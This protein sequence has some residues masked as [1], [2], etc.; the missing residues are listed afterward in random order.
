MFVE[1]D[2]E[3]DGILIVRELFDAERVGRLLAVAEELLHKFRTLNP[4]DGKPASKEAKSLFQIHH[5]G[6]FAPGSPELR[7]LLEAVADPQVLDLVRDTCNT[8]DPMFSHTS[9]F[10]NPEEFNP[11][12][13]AEHLG[14]SECC[15]EWHRDAQYIHPNEEDEKGLVLHP[16]EVMGGQ[17]MQV[18]IPS[19]GI[20]PIPRQER[21]G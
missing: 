10:F 17:M 4:I 11:P 18:R 2:W 14:S 6:F 1:G 5:P 3:R 15:G 8:A 13:A 19:S 21:L 16:E 7:E 20:S 12:P 9:I